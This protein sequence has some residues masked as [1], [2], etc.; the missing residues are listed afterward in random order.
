MEGDKPLL[1]KFELYP[2][3]PNPFNPTANI[4]FNLP[5]SGQVNLAVYNNIGQVVAT[6]SNG[7]L[8]A[9]E[10]R[11]VWNAT[12]FASGVYYLML[13]ASEGEKVQKLLL[14]K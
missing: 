2:V 9:G 12:D 13:R 3:Y 7:Y 8:N 1:S 11:M 5:V 10:H 4:R 14:I 6:I